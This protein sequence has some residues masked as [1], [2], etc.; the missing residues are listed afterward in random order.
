MKLNKILVYLICLL[1]SI[2]SVNAQDITSLYLIQNAP[3]ENLV[4]I[5][6][7]FLTQLHYRMLYKNDFYVLPP[8]AKDDSKTFY[9]IIIT[10]NSNNCYLYYSANDGTIEPL[11]LK[12]IKKGHYKIK[13]L[14]SANVDKIWIEKATNLK[15]NAEVRLSNSHSYDFSSKAQ[16][17]FDQENNI[18]IAQELQLPRS[19]PRQYNVEKTKTSYRPIYSMPQV[20]KKAKSIPEMAVKNVVDNYVLKGAVVTIAKGTVLGA[21]LQSSVSSASLAQSDKITAVL[22]EDFKYNGYLI[23]PAQT[24]I[25]G[26]AIKANSAS[27]AYGNGSLELSFNQA[28]LPNGNK[29]NISTEKIS[30]VKN[31]E[32]AVN[33][34]KN[35][36]AGAGIGILTGLLSAVSTGD[37]AQAALIGASIGSAGGGIYA[38]T[39]KGQE[40]EIS[41]GTKLNLRI[42]EPINIS[43]YKE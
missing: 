26:D 36:V 21:T 29:I 31:S 32:R 8:N 5:V 22:D 20:L 2:S 10:Q 39:Q 9:E 41:E 40:I 35:V 7:N 38:V 6:D 1:L 23:F 25:Y 11:L 27:C 15:S 4:N 19:Q 17:E 30:Y 3:R 18:P 43:P 33:I 14:P 12:E 13:K 28:L 34:T 16:E 42:S 24:V 37:Y